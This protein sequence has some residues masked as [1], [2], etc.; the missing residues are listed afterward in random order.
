MKKKSNANTSR[1]SYQLLIFIEN[2]A[3]TLCKYKCISWKRCSW[4]WEKYWRMRGVLSGVAYF[5]ACSSNS[6][7]TRSRS[8]PVLTH[9]PRSFMIYLYTSIK[10]ART[11]LRVFMCALNKIIIIMTSLEVRTLEKIREKISTQRCKKFLRAFDE[12]DANPLF[13]RLI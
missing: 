4:E 11:S 3:G 6:P 9:D 1:N 8:M 13:K 7:S 10:Y 5:G 2:L 12:D